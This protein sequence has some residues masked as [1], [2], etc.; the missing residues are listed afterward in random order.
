[1]SR[2]KSSPSKKRHLKFK[3][4]KKWLFLGLF[5]WIIS[6]FIDVWPIIFLTFFSV[7]NSMMLSFKRYFDAPADI[8]LSTFSAILMTNQYGLTY[9]I[10]TAIVTKLVSMLYIKVIK[11]NYFFMMTSYVVAAILAEVFSGMNIVTLG[12]LVTGLSNIYVSF[13]RKFV[14]QYSTFEII[15][16]GLTN[17]IF[18]VVMFVGFAELVLKIMI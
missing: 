4:D 2:K 15:S 11:V 18:N 1:M 7:L 17:I 16:Y 3:V 10:I 14:V 8:E 5:V 12:L 9:G 13:V 6:F